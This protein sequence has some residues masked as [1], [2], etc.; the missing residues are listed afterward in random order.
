MIYRI[1][2]ELN[3]HY[4]EGDGM[5]NCKHIESNMPTESDTSLARSNFKMTKLRT[6]GRIANRTALIFRRTIF[7]AWISASTCAMAS[8]NVSS[9]STAF[10][11]GGAVTVSASKGLPRFKYLREN[12]KTAQ[13]AKRDGNKYLV[14][15]LNKRWILHNT[16]V[17]HLGYHSFTLT[18][19]ADRGAITAS[20]DTV[21]TQWNKQK[22]HTL[23][24]IA[25][26]TSTPTLYCFCNP[27][28]FYQRI[29]SFQII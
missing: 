2:Y 9:C 12:M 11:T 15:S 27:F 3:K 24:S 23:S 6:C 18:I 13:H 16:L 19:C 7:P 22:A 8:C 28:L 10:L 1:Y 17:S 14:Q 29:H 20:Y 21:T 25:P 5:S 4:R 26:N